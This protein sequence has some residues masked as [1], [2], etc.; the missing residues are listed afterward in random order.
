VAH[1]LLPEM[2]PALVERLGGLLNTCCPACES[3]ALA[4]ARAAVDGPH[5]I[6]G[7]CGETFMLVPVAILMSEPGM[8]DAYSSGPL[9]DDPGWAAVDELAAMMPSPA[10]FFDV[11]Q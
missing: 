5:V 2:Q 10:A 6:C 8:P 7:F 11:P 3:D 4:F 9:L 1:L